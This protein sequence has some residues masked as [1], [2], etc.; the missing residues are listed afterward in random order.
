MVRAAGSRWKIEECIE[1]A[2]GEVGLDEYEV[3]LWLAWYRHITLAMFAQAFLP[4][5]RAQAQLEACATG[6]TLTPTALLPSAAMAA[7]AQ[8]LLPL[9]VPEVRRLLWQFALKREPSSLHGLAWSY[10]RRRHQ[11]QAKDDP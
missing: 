11:A 4:V 5:V 10:W 3:R 1:A 9:T 2:T 6:Q 8:A 7:A